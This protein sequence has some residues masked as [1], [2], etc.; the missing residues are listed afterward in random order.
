[1]KSWKFLTRQLRATPLTTKAGHLVRNER[2]R[3]WGLV[4]WD[5]KKFRFETGETGVILV[6]DTEVRSS[7][8]WPLEDLSVIVEKG[9]IIWENPELGKILDQQWREDEV[10]NV[11]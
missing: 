9:K 10:E 2:Q 5:E 3:R 4:L 6:W 8:N 11:N 1:M 7:R